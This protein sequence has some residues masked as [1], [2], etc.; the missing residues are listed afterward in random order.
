MFGGGEE[1]GEEEFED[2]LEVDDKELDRV[3]LIA[4]DDDPAK[5]SMWLTDGAD[6]E[7]HS[8]RSVRSDLVMLKH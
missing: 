8:M 6:V 3:R 4:L 7:G 1:L 2:E 5:E